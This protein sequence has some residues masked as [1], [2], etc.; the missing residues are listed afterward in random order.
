MV[1]L[2][3]KF[4]PYTSDAWAHTEILRVGHHEDFRLDDFIRK[5]SNLSA[6][7]LVPEGTEIEYSR[8]IWT[9]SPQV[10]S[11]TRA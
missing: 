6:V 7:V 1:K 8:S 3:V 2:L 10:V 9:M 4:K 11:V 5:D